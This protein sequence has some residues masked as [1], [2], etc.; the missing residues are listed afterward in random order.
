MKENNI[1]FAANTTA[2]LP[3]ARARYLNQAIQL[4]ET[5]PSHII[6]TAISFS[7]VLIVLLVIWS[8]ITHIKE[9]AA[10]RGEVIPAGYIQN[11]Q[12]LE[13]GIVSE[14]LVRNGD[15]VEK[16]QP[17]VRLA[18]PA[19]LSELEQMQVRHASLYLQAERLQA[20]IDKREPDFG[21]VGSEYPYLANKQRT[22]YF[23]QLNSHQQQVKVIEQ[24][25]AQKQ[26]EKQRMLNQSQLMKEEVKMLEEQVNSRL[27]LSSKG[28]VAREELLQTQI[29]LSENQR[30][31]REFSDNHSVAETALAET[32]LRLSEVKSGFIKDMQLEA[33]KVIN[34]LA[35]VEQTLI[36][37]NDRVTRLSVVAPVGGIVQAL[38][39][40]SINEVLEPG[41]T[42]L[43]IVP[44]ED[45]LIVEARIMPNDIGHVHIGQTADIKVDSYDPSRLGSVSGTVKRISATTYL[46][47]KNNPYYRAEINL[48][49]TWMGQDRELLKIIPGMTV[50]ANIETGE[51][52]ILAYLLRP[53]SRGFDNAFTER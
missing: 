42:I 50:L 47:E 44:V 17:L 45:D 15:L 24:Q 53:I 4:E 16:G 26:S 11:V 35:E 38:T 33:G 39:V 52:S 34:Q 2:G 23:A 21:E 27:Q 30:E 13:G 18:P 1:V 6:N 36:R 12:H 43:R 49:K 7:I 19:T 51:K 40:N 48:D 46:D 25:I 8:H 31:Q 32:R 28:V 37:L 29:R 22:I 41:K 20:L 5:I 10:A 9:V 3:R 14:I